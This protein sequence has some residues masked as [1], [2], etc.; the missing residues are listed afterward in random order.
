MV[1]VSRFAGLL[2][3]F[4]ANTDLETESV[5]VTDF[6]FSLAICNKV[7]MPVGEQRLCSVAVAM[8]NINV[9]P[10]RWWGLRFE[11][12]WVVNLF[13]VL[14]LVLALDFFPRH[15]DRRGV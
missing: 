15:I 1:V 13:P 3:R 4:R 5:R 2:K 10:R 14:V 11:W 9:Q 12:T 6:F 8:I 7:P